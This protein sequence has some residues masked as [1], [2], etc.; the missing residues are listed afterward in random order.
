MSA[1]DPTGGDASG[2]PVAPDPAADALKPERPMPLPRWLRGSTRREGRVR[3]PLWLTVGAN[4]VI[5]IGLGTWGFS[6]LALKPKLNFF[7][8]LYRAVKLYTLDLGPTATGG[9]APHPNWQL[10]VAL[11]FAAA[12]VLRALLALGRDRLAGFAMRRILR[13]HVIV[14][15]GGVHGTA[16]V[17]ALAGGRGPGEPGTPDDEEHDVVLI[18]RDPLSASLRSAPAKREWRIVG[19]AIAGEALLKAGAARAHMIV[20]ITGNDFVNS[21]IVSSVREL[22]MQR[23]VKNRVHVLVQV[24]DPSLARFLEEESELSHDAAAAVPVVSPFSANSI[25]AAA[26]VGEAKVKLDSGE[27]DTLLRMR[28]GEAPSLLLAGDHPLIDAIVL[29]VLRRWRVRIMRELEQSST[30]HRPPLRM[31]VY[32]PGAVARVERLRRRWQPEAQV[33]TLEGFDSEP[34]GDGAGE[35]E[36]WQRKAHEWLRES[37]RADHAIVV[38]L[39]ELDAVRQTLELSDVLGERVLITRVSTLSESVL[40]EHIKDRLASTDVRSL[41]RLACKPKKMDRL[42]A[43]QRLADALESP[44][45][46]TREAR[47]SAKAFFAA[48]KLELYSDF[49]WRVPPSEQ[50]LLEALV[51]PVPVSALLRAGLRVNLDT[52]ENLRSAAQAMSARGVHDD[53]FPAWCEYA[54]T[55]DASS[56]PA[57]RLELQS[58]AHDDLA[59]AV[60]RLRAFTLGDARALKIPAHENILTG[61]RRV[62]IFAGGAKS[63]SET[64]AEELE[65]LLERGL[66]GYAGTI[67]SGGTEV[68]LPG[69]VGRVASRLGLPTVGYVPA[70]RG[71]PEL[72]GR[73]RET[74]SDEFSVR[75]PLAMWED[76]LGSGIPAQNVRVVVCPGG[77]ITIGEVLLARA[78]G[79]PVAWIDPAGAAGLPLE[80]MLPLGAD[81]VLEPPV[82][83]MTI[84]AFLMWSQVPPELREPLARS[85]HNSYR[86]RQR[87][88]K[89]PGDPALAP[90]DE[91][92]RT[93]RNSN[94]AQADDIPNKLALVGRKLDR[95]GER[96]TLDLGEVELLAELEHGR[97]NIERLLAGWRLGERRVERGASPYLKPWNELTEEAKDYDR[98]AIANIGPALREL[99]WGVVAT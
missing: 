63:M 77:Q 28:D 44:H 6:E 50:P 75:E 60:L 68:G 27:E 23:R 97:F 36:S 91:L 88:R 70:G 7:E 10:W 30:E 58:L 74:A 81:G 2:T 24:E 92:I 62:A 59:A 89:A 11:A 3:L 31:S 71:D 99:G 37:R 22:A 5:T 38:C 17:T 64:T 46:N 16:L 40:D 61:T 20:A 35:I 83:A 48:T 84:R 13:G 25:A 42:G 96:L 32:G 76:I 1:G 66:M 8:S 18:D 55:L 9:G 21:Q 26:L 4:I 67:L 87:R 72:Y 54:R 98:E 34:A 33:L 43:E 53:A 69:V 41:P 90:W 73:L 86:R 29:D 79:A 85:L 45:L 78:L 95:P 15:G 57:L 12:L 39:D 94:L 82:D 14:C 51:S 47:V 80:D 56:L 52:P 93:F 49:T 19:D 65:P